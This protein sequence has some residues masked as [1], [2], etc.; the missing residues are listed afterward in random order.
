M[1]LTIRPI[2]L[3]TLRIDKSLNTYM[4]HCGVPLD[5]PMLAFYIE[6][7]SKRI[8]VDTGPPDPDWAAKHH[9]PIT[10]TDE[11]RLPRALSQVGVSVEEIDVV[12]HT[13]L[14]WDHAFNGQLFKNAQFF[15]QRSEL[16]FAAAPIPTQIR[17]YQSPATG[18]VPPYLGIR[19][20]VLD[21]DAE[22]VP[23]V[24]VILTPGHTAGF[25]SVSVETKQGTYVIAG[26]TVPLYE[27]WDG[28]PP[29]V[30]HIP[31]T[32]H[33]NLDEYFVSFSK[34][35]RVADV[36]LPGHDPRVLDHARY[37]Q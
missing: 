25:Q 8:L 13:H 9:R 7:A 37:P 18:L 1:D 23:G 31:N 26:D 24:G 12:I 4:V 5:Q 27:N 30:P 33:V 11:Q 15:V 28:L 17:G 20:T 36:V 29:Y 3:G 16:A 35:E 21:G 34:I 32:I 22:I 19:Y 10:V 2:N 6:G 14:H